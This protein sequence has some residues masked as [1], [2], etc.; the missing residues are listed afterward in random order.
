M[1]KNNNLYKNQKAVLATMHK[2]EQVMAPVLKRELG[3]EVV[4]PEHLNTDDFG[5][6]TNDV[7]RV[8]D[9]LEAARTKLETAMLQSG[10]SIGLASEGS[11]SSHPIISFLPFNR[12][13]VLFVDKERD[14][15]IT[16]FV[17]NGNTNYAGKVVG[18]FE[19]AYEFALAQGFP[20][21]GVI[22]K[23]TEDT[24]NPKE[25]EKGIVNAERLK[26]A[27]SD[28]LSVSGKSVFIQTD[29]RAMF[30]PTRMKNIELATLDLVQKLQTLCPACSTPGY[31]VVEYKKGLECE[32]CGNATEA[33]RSHL[34]KCKKCTHEEEIQ[35][36]NGKEY[37]DPARCNWCNP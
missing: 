26:Q 13:L 36:P 6:F 12:E 22:V 9:Q 16:G 8:G 1:K 15:E 11:F 33:V 37:A 32:C 21:H 3:I 24:L 31:E 30:N 5:T 17:A 2:K 29:M 23:A 7:E 35:F 25:M 14:L 28:M 19:E 27:V 10:L 34:Y 4:V 20:D 18:S